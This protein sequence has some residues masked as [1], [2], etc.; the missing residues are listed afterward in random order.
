MSIHICISIY[1]LFVLFVII[2]WL[3][4][5]SPQEIGFEMLRVLTVG[6]FPAIWHSSILVGD[7]GQNT[8]WKRQNSI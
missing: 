7:A 6:S 5:E 8:W 3:N 2:Y 4:S 1:L